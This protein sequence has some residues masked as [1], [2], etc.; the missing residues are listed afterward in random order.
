MEDWKYLSVWGMISRVGVHGGPTKIIFQLNKN[1]FRIRLFPVV[2]WVQLV[3]SILCGKSIDWYKS[4]KLRRQRWRDDFRVIPAVP[5]DE[6]WD[7]QDCCFMT[8]ERMFQR[9][10]EGYTWMDMHHKSLFYMDCILL[11]FSSW[12][13]YWSIC[14]AHWALMKWNEKKKKNSSIQFGFNLNRKTNSLCNYLN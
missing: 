3:S 14:I 11:K 7:S 13:L 9:A 2:W 4:S 12:A 10:G 8:E 6:V 1:F 5:A